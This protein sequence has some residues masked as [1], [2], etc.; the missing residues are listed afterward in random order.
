MEHPAYD[1][2]FVNNLDMDTGVVLNYGLDDEQF[3]GGNPLMSAFD[4]SHMLSTFTG[5]ILKACV[6]SA[7]VN[8]VQGGRALVTGFRALV[9]GTSPNT[10]VRIGYRDS[11]AGTV[12]WTSELTPNNITEL[13][14]TLIDA[15]Y[16]RFEINVDGDYDFIF[17]GEPEF[18]SAGYQ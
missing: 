16:H 12:N 13:A 11:V 4:T 8:F 6:Q 5:P 1:G 18:E 7:E 14:D 3:K 10:T 17:G 2:I 9:D 15:R